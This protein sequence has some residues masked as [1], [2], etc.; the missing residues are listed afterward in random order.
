MVI[1][2]PLLLNVK[3]VTVGNM[4]I[5]GVIDDAPLKA[6]TVVDVDVVPINV[7]LAFARKV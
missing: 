4:P 1:V 5:V 3:P 7:P 6:V 2:V